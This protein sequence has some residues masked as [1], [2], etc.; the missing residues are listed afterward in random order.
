MPELII[1]DEWVLKKLGY[2]AN[3]ARPGLIAPGF[4]IG[5]ESLFSNENIQAFLKSLNISLESFEQIY[6][7]ALG[8][9]KFISIT[10][11]RYRDHLSHSVRV[12][13]LGHFLLKEVLFSPSQI[14]LCEHLC[15]QNNLSNNDF[16]KSWWIASLFHDICYPISKLDSSIKSIIK[17]VNCVFHPYSIIQKPPVLDFMTDDKTLRD[18][19]QTLKKNMKKSLSRGAYQDFEF[20]LN[21]TINSEKMDHGVLGA[22]FLLMLNED[23]DDTTVLDATKAIALHN[24]KT[25]L[26]FEEEPLASFLILCDEIQEWGRGVRE[27]TGDFYSFKTRVLI[28]KMKFAA[29]D[30]SFSF[31]STFENELDLKKTDFQTD[32]FDKG[33]HANL[34]RI[35]RKREFPTFT[36]SYDI[37]GKSYQF[38]KTI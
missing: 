4:N 9:E 22:L 24:L 25:E 23:K 2:W 36:I 35:K 19:L 30:D 31:H 10:N 1:N 33:K 18:S 34:G 16:I 38:S 20:A 8:L 13:V 26:V 21:S 17:Q 37:K 29:E 28:K 27:V 15:E 7:K 6:D 32:K 14:T 12:A 5:W 3:L 11:S